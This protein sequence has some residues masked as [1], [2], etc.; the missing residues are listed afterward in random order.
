MKVKGTKQIFHLTNLSEEILSNTDPKYKALLLYINTSRYVKQT[1]RKLLTD[2]QETDL[3]SFK[4]Q[5]IYIMPFLPLNLNMNSF[6]T[7][8]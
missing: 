6:K 1:A 8:C 3:S 7:V 4:M 2:F 5:E